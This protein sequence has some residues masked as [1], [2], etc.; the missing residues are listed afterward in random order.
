MVEIIGTY[1]RKYSTDVRVFY[2]TLVQQVVQIH[3]DSTEQ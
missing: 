2:E 3:Y 1:H